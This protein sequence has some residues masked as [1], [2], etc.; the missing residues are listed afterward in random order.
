[1]VVCGLILETQV[2]D[3]GMQGNGWGR[4]TVGGGTRLPLPTLLAES[5]WVCDGI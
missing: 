1:M 2:G 5:F 4:G 3:V